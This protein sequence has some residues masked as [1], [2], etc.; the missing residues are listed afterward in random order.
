MI[1]IKTLRNR[2]KDGK[3]II[4]V[5][6]D[7]ERFDL[8]MSDIINR[9]ECTIRPSTNGK[10]VTVA[11]VAGMDSVCISPKNGY[12][13]S[14]SGS[15]DSRKLTS[16]AIATVKRLAESTSAY[17]TAVRWLLAGKTI[18]AEGTAFS[19]PWISSLK[20]DLRDI[21]GV[22]IIS[23]KN[24][25]ARNGRQRFGYYLTCPELFKD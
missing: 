7:D 14:E 19:Y 10:P 6:C 16:E 12:G 24:V 3:N 23:K 15:N 5:I 13:C 11:A 20:A 17:G 22:D 25:K 8:M 18:T 4:A 9:Y 2:L 1:E 21:A